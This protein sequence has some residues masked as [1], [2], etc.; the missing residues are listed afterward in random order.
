MSFF[1]SLRV[2]LA[3]PFVALRWQLTSLYGDSWWADEAQAAD[4]QL[5]YNGNAVAWGST[6]VADDKSNPSAEQPPNLVDLNA[7][8]K[9]LAFQTGPKRTR[10][11]VDFTSN[12]GGWVFNQYRYRTAND[13]Q[14]RDPTGWV[15]YGSYDGTNFIEIGRETNAVNISARK[16]WT[17]TFNLTI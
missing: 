16:T 4:F 17:N 9:W 8:T 14:G 11:R 6:T 7:N 10:V 13:D 5:L 12:A 1:P 15:L 3:K 2:N